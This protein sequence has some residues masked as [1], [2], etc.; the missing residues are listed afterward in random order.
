[1]GFADKESQTSREGKENVLCYVFKKH[2]E[3]AMQF[4]K[5]FFVYPLLYLY[6]IAL[7]IIDNEGGE[8]LETI[9]TL[10]QSERKNSF[11]DGTSVKSKGTR[12]RA[13]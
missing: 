9:R 6:C 4:H 11:G 8:G 13:L 10:Y 1:M 3:S 2:I 12:T 7:L 5:L